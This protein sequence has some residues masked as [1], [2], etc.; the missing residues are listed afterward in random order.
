MPYVYVHDTLNYKAVAPKMRQV[1]EGGH[2]A[3]KGE[4]E[5]VV[6]ARAEATRR[7]KV[8]RGRCEIL[9][10]VRDMSIGVFYTPVSMCHR[11]CL[12]TPVSICL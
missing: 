5:V 9:S 8:A 6:R 11:S 4:V 12:H 7:T 3:T 1:G 2:S 10:V